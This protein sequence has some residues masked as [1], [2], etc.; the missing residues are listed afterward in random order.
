VR[1][2]A[3]V[4]L[5]GKSCGIT[6]TPPFEST[7]ATPS[8]PGTTPWKSRWSTSGRTALS[9]TL[10]GARSASHADERAQA[11]RQHAA[12]AV[13]PVRAVR[14]EPSTGW[15]VVHGEAIEAEG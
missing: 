14:L 6:W 10:A 7:S 12:D 4:K 3:E 9:A 11:H 13:W 1:E 15:V 5:N 8:K 2:L